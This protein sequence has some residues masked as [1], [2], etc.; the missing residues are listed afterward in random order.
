MCVLRGEGG[1]ELNFTLHPGHLMSNNNNPSVGPVAPSTRPRLWTDSALD[2]SKSSCV[3]Q[4]GQQGLTFQ[5]SSWRSP[6]GR[7]RTRLSG[8]I[9]RKVEEQ[10][11]RSMLFI[12]D[13]L[14][15][16]SVRLNIF[17]E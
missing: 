10:E 3:R 2:V 6:S 11:G 5:M 15:S 16:R 14:V 8:R 1:I 13:W 9:G 4:C 12:R 7:E 17:Q